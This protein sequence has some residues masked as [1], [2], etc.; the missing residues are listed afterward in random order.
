MVKYFVNGTICY[1]NNVI[2]FYA[3][4]VTNFSWEAIQLD[5]VY[6]ETLMLLKFGE[7]LLIAKKGTYCILI[8]VLTLRRVLVWLKFVKFVKSFPIY[9]TGPYQLEIISTPL[10]Y[11]R[12]SKIQVISALRVT[13]CTH[14]VAKTALKIVNLVPYHKVGI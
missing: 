7:L 11:V 8:M 9:G 6:W 1:E 13:T 5:T 2:I 4:T 14:D 12:L 3:Y 10:S